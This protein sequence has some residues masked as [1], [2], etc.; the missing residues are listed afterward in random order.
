MMVITTTFALDD[1]FTFTSV[2]VFHV[3]CN[4]STLFLILPFKDLFLRRANVWYICH[5]QHKEMANIYAF[6]LCVSNVS[7]V[8]LKMETLLNQQPSI[9]CH[10]FPLNHVWY[11]WYLQRRNQYLQELSHPVHNFAF[12]CIK[13]INNILPASYFPARL[14]GHHFSCLCSKGSNPWLNVH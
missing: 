8:Y 11:V 2:R 9:S 10:L 12:P 3:Q 6:I 5:H 13:R 7:N 1:L 14:D 4:V